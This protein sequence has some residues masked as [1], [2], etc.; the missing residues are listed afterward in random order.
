VATA[1]TNSTNRKNAPTGLASLDNAH[2][3]ISH[4]IRRVLLVVIAVL[5]VIL[6]VRQVRASHDASTAKAYAALANA[7]TFEDFER[8]AAD[9]AGTT[10]AQ[11]A[12]LAA[13]KDLFA[14]GNYPLAA[15]RFAAAAASGNEILS[16]QGTLGQAAVCEVLGQ[17]D[18]SQL[19]KAIE[20]FKT[21]G[22]KAATL[23]QTS[24]QVDAMLGQVRCYR[25]SGDATKSQ[26]LLDAAKK[27]IAPLGKNKGDASEFSALNR[28]VSGAED[29]LAAYALAEA[30]PVSAEPTPAPAEPAPAEKAAN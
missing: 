14:Q 18:A 3:E 17:Q 21:A 16:L 13:A 19:P 15:D 23:G 4:W 7:V 29:A 30:A 5:A 10:V 20:F 12:Q 1:N 26:E 27:L 24:A 2:P 8:V 28:E 6:V 25:Q 22:G 9:F 11:Q